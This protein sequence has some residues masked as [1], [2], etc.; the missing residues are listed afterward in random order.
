M[1]DVPPCA[2]S[3]EP[4]DVEAVRPDI[5]GLI[6]SRGISM[7]SAQDLRELLKEMADRKVCVFV[8]KDD[9]C[10]RIHLHSIG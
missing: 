1:T 10:I 7:P 9:V 5:E 8:M 6:V 3:D 2:L 4:C